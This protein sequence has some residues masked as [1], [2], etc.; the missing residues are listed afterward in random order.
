MDSNDQIAADATV[1]VREGG[2]RALAA[3]EVLCHELLIDDGQSRANVAAEESTREEGPQGIERLKLARQRAR[4]ERAQLE[5]ERYQRESKREDE[6][7]QLRSEYLSRSFLLVEKVIMY[8]ILIVILSGSGL[9]KVSDAILA[10]ILGTTLANVIGILLV[11]F[12]WLY[13]RT[14]KK[15]D[16]KN[17]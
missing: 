12:V 15:K 10:T 11:A 7:Q 14:Q 3:S 9:L 13:P 16:A 1:R 5:N 4:A 2:E 8:S 17:G 6:K